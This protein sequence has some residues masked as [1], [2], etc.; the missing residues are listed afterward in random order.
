M[1][2]ENEVPSDQFPEEWKNINFPELFAKGWRPRLKKKGDKQYITLRCS[3][4][5]E[6][7]KKDRERSLGPFTSEKWELMQKLFPH[8]T[9]DLEDEGKPDLVLSKKML[10]TNI[11]RHKDIPSSMSIDT[12]ILQYYEWVKKKGYDEPLDRFI[13]DCVRNYFIQ[14]G[15]GI[16]IKIKRDVE[17]S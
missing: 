4:K 17:V 13:Q 10:A 16:A 12:D 14:N 11:G 6:G 7:E 1:S 15:F 8:R 5:E 3:R 9:W 2:E